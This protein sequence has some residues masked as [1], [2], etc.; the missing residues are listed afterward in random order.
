M[1]ERKSLRII[2]KKIC[3]VMKQFNFLTTIGL[4]LTNHKTYIQRK[5]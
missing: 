5:I 4:S 3:W 2:L 1:E